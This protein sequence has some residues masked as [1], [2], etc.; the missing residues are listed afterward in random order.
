MKIPV[1]LACA[2]AAFCFSTAAVDPALNQLPGAMHVEMKERP[3][4]RVGIKGMRCRR[5]G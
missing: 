3:H 5:R 2:S 1:V 4:V